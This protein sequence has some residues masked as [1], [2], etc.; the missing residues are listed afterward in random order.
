MCGKCIMKMDH[1]CPWVGN[2]IGHRNHKFFWQFLL[3]F[4]GMLWHMALTMTTH[5]AEIDP[6]NYGF[7]VFYG[8][9][10]FWTNG[11]TLLFLAQTV[12][13]AHNWAIVE[14]C[15]LWEENIYKH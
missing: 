11:I 2:C 12:E 5:R 7:Y 10:L 15:N 8:L 13:I 6:D 1:H 9:T 14:S 3:Y 4:G